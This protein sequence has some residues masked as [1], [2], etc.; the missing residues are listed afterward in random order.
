MK[1]GICQKCVLFEIQYSMAFRK[2]LSQWEKGNNFELYFA[3]SESFGVIFYMC[4]ISALYICTVNV[5][6]KYSNLLNCYSKKKKMYFTSIFCDK[7]FEWYSMRNKKEKNILNI[8]FFLPHLS[9]LSKTNASLYLVNRLIF[10]YKV[11]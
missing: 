10:L 2:K 8:I 7:H 3:S 5:I 4:T 6:K 11:S 1:S 9:I